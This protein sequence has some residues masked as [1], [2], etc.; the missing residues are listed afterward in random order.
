MYYG[1]EMNALNFGIKGSKLDFLVNCITCGYGERWR[2][3]TGQQK[4][5]T[6]KF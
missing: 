6:L 2:R 5:A 1:T 4:S 3:S